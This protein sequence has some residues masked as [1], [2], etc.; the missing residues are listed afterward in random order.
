MPVYWCVSHHIAEQRLYSTHAAPL[1]RR[2]IINSRHLYIC[3]QTPHRAV[4][5]S[6]YI[7]NAH[8]IPLTPSTCDAAY[9]EQFCSSKNVKRDTFFS[10]AH[11]HTLCLPHRVRV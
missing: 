11:T 3:A 6:V 4:C 5:A 2:T 10:A 7:Q 8:I 9:L 1:M